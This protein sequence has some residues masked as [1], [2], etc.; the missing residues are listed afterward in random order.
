MA[1]L[2]FLLLPGHADERAL[3]VVVDDLRA[4]SRSPLHFLFVGWVAFVKQ[5]HKSRSEQNTAFLL[6]LNEDFNTNLSVHYATAD[7]SCFAK[8]NLRPSHTSCVISVSA[9]HCLLLIFSALI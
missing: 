7:S 8:L 1:A 9:W 6:E 2:P 5:K 3:D 4:T